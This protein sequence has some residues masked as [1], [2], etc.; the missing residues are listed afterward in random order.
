MEQDASNKTR[1]IAIGFAAKLKSWLFRFHVGLRALGAPGAPGA[2]CAQGAQGAQ[3]ASA[4]LG[5]LGAQSCL[6]RSRS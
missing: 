5:A 4:A 6:R 3:G 1:Y 2:Q